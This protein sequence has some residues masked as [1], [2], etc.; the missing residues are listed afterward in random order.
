MIPPHFTKTWGI[1]MKKEFMNAARK[2]GTFFAAGIMAL[3]LSFNAQAQDDLPFPSFPASFE[4]SVY[5]GQQGCMPNDSRYL[6]AV[7]KNEGLDYVGSHSQLTTASDGSFI[8]HLVNGKD[9]NYGYILE[10]RGNGAY[11]VNQK[12]TNFKDHDQLNLIQVNH[13]QALKPEDCTFEP[14]VLNLCGTFERL[15]AR[16][17]NAGYSQDWQA[18]NERGNTMTMFSGTGQS[19]ILTTNAQTGATIFTG[20]GKGEFVPASPAKPNN[21]SALVAKN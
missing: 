14:Q 9:K 4:A 15:S 2:V 11:C 21:Q 10:N 1:Q 12:I 19:W 5:Q 6:F 8:M 7:A 13:R 20:A 17:I 3:G 18:K 16:L